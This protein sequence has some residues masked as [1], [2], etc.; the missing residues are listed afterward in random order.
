MKP[1]KKLSHVYERVVARYITKHRPR[2]RKEIRHFE[3]M[4]SLEE[5]VSEAALSK[6]TTGKRH[7]HQR[8]IPSTALNQVRKALLGIKLSKFRSFEELHEKIKSTIG[9]IPKIGP[10]AIYDI[11]HRIGAYLRLEPEYV[12]LHCGVTIGAKALGLNTHR[13]KLSPIELP[14]PFRK[15]KADE[16]ED[17]LCIFKHELVGIKSGRAS[18]CTPHHRK[19]SVR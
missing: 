14:A 4:P 19:G 2:S 18:V 16:I 5:A 1:T 3:R 7:P 9:N 17:C 10:L 12:Y 15:L 8:R 13:D 11:S 6:S